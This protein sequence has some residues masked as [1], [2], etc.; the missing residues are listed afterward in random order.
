[1]P[2]AGVVS[3]AFV[4]GY[5]R[6]PLRA[7]RNP[8][9]GHASTVRAPGLPGWSRNRARRLHVDL[10]E[11]SARKDLRLVVGGDA[12]FETNLRRERQLECIAKA[13]AAGV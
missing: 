7:A 3:E 11:L 13:K 1:M 9:T 5:W 10:R 2:Q 12:E 4:V 6:E 8:L